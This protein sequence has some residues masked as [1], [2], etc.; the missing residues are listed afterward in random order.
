[1]EKIYEEIAM[2]GGLDSH[3]EYANYYLK[4]IYGLFDTVEHI[5]ENKYLLDHLEYGSFGS[6]G[7]RFYGLFPTIFNNCKDYHAKAALLDL[8]NTGKFRLLTDRT[9]IDEDM[10]Y[11]LY[12]V[13]KEEKEHKEDVMF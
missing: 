3:N 8:V 1:M 12:Q 13:K 9:M 7:D 2:D 10:K 11:F 6:T 5:N 4:E